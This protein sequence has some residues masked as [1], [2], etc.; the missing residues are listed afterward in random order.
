MD[1]FQTRPFLWTG[2]NDNPRLR[3]L[4]IQQVISGAVQHKAGRPAVIH[5]IKGAFRR[6]V[7]G[8]KYGENHGDLIG[9]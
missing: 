7:S 5:H 2:S 4:R 3:G 6:I 8:T 1:N 9:I